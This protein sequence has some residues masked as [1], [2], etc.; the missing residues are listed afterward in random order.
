MVVYALLNLISVLESLLIFALFV[1]AI[2]SYFLDYY[3]PIRQFLSRFIEPLL[4]PIRRFLPATGAVDFSPIILFVIVRI[5]F[6]L[7]SRSIIFL[8]MR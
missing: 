7:L 1:W 4:Q 6:S 5:V 3:H 2:S 8:F